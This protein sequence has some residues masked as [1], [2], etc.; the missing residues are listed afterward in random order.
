[1]TSRQFDHHKCPAIADVNIKE[2][3][4]FEEYSTACDVAARAY[5]N[6]EATR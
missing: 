6:E 5:R 3:K 1:M 2:F 4:S